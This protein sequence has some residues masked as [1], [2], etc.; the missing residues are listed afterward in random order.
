MAPPIVE[1]YLHLRKTGSPSHAPCIHILHMLYATCSG[2]LPVNEGVATCRSRG[3]CR[4]YGLKIPVHS[5]IGETRHAK[6]CRVVLGAPG[7]PPTGRLPCKEMG[8]D[9]SFLTATKWLGKPTWMWVIFL[10]VVG[11]AL[12][13]LAGGV[14]VSVRSLGTRFLGSRAQVIRGLDLSS[15]EQ[16]ARGLE[17]CPIMARVGE[18]RHSAP[19]LRPSGQLTGRTQ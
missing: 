10:T 18:P 17:R 8:M 19:G 14:I 2:K 3:M 7:P 15:A 13:L 1:A 9:F 4:Q 12:G 6:A 11:V 5:T 16:G